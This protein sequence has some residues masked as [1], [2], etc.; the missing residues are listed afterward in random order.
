LD[1]VQ[2]AATVALRSAE[3]KKQFDSQDAVP[4]PMS[5]AEFAAF[6]KTEQAKWGPVVLETGAK[7]E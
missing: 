5:P 1:K 2:R 3:L 4:S 7:L 6:V